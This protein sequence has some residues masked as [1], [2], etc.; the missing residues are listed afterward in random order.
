MDE[1]KINIINDI[2]IVKVEI[3]VATYRDAKSLWE[4]MESALIFNH[5]KIIIDLS[6]CNSV[7]STFIGM[8]VKISRKV[9]EKDGQ[10]KLVFPQMTTAE[11]FLITSISQII[12]CY[13]TLEE[14]MNSFD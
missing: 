11:I 13:D 1:F 3:L 12:D 2:A 9:R 14:A 4:E 8:I 5:K 7:D 6:H 10:M